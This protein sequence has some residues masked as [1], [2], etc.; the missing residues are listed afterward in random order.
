MKKHL[1]D[2]LL[3][4]SKTWETRSF[5]IRNTFYT[6]KPYGAFTCI[7]SYCIWSFV[8]INRQFF[9]PALIE[10]LLKHISISHDNLRTLPSEAPIAAMLSASSQAGQLRT[11]FSIHPYSMSGQNPPHAPGVRSILN[12]SPCTEDPQASQKSQNTRAPFIS[13]PN[14]RNSHMGLSAKSKISG[15]VSNRVGATEVRCGFSPALAGVENATAGAVSSFPAKAGELSPGTFRDLLRKPGQVSNRVGA[16]EERCGS[17]AASMPSHPH[18]SLSRRLPPERHRETPRF[19]I[20][21][22]KG[23]ENSLI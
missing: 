14:I 8:G 17:A 19:S 21:H 16:T 10:I 20:I 4:K 22:N 1:W 5:W 12:P 6:N 23:F 15:Q 11:D 18:Q 9:M 7:C 13:V 3:K 2:I